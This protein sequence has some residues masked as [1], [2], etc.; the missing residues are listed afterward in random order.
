MEPEEKKN[1]EKDIDIRKVTVKP[2]DNLVNKKIKFGVIGEENCIFSPED[3]VM[4]DFFIFCKNF[5]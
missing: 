2:C 4:I 5:Y 3:Q 1:E